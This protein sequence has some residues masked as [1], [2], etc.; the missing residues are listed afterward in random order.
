[1]TGIDLQRL[2]R[3]GKEGGWIIIGQLATMAGA[4]AMVRFLTEYL[5]PTQYGQLA[6]GLTAVGLTNQVIIGGLAAGIGRFYPIAAEQKDLGN[7]ISDVLRL[8]VFGSA[9]VVCFGIALI[10]GVD[11]LGYPEWIG[12]T[13]SAAVF[14]LLSGYNATLS[15]IQ[16][17]ARQRSVVALHVAL[18]AWL[19]IVLSLTVMRYFGVGSTPVVVGYS[20]SVLLVMVSQFAFLKAGGFNA[21]VSERNEKEKWISR[22]LAYS[23]PFSAWGSFIWIQ[24]VS[25]RWSLGFFG[26]TADVG[27]Y[28]VLFQLGYTPILMI[29]GVTIN[30]IG[31]ILYVR[32]GD[33]TSPVRNAIVNRIVFWLSVGM[34]TVSIGC[35]FLL[36]LCHEWIFGLLVARE[37][38]SSSML[39]PW[40]TLASG[41]FSVGQIISLKSYSEMKPKELLKLK[42]VTAILGSVLNV[43]GAY[44]AGVSGVVSA[45]VAFSVAYLIW[46]VVLARS[47][48]PS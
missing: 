36:L 45:L 27:L 10:L 1:M 35:F 38:R 31:P 23:W 4:L 48:A 17:A 47:G 44:L 46:I 2:F 30:F 18:D 6:L 3:L 16:N 33:A 9:A 13:A 39:L 15:S 25:D 8:L 11:I 21:E 43:V 20:I 37:Y 42:I 34:F 22:I 5:S 12:L 40:V 41:L 19:R 24:Q 28:A 7:Y 14:A 26:S 29:T 32:S